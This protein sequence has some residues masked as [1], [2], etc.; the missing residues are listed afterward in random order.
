MYRKKLAAQL[1][2]IFNIEIVRY[3]LPSESFEQEAIFIDIADSKC[4]AD[5]DGFSSARVR[6]SI[7]VFL[8]SDKMPFGYMA[9]NI[10][11]A[12]VNDT[13][14]FFFHNIEQNLKYYGKLVERRC[15]FIY[16]Y[17]EQYDPDHGT[18]NEIEFNEV[19]K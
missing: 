17:R 15:D 19:I 4:K 9:K 6:G 2:R 11:R 8:N 1:Q 18:M 10:Q 3:D 12:R 13:K 7:S 14:D 16:F 5:T